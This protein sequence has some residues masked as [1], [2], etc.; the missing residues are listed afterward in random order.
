M[1]R[2]IKKITSKKWKLVGSGWKNTPGTNLTFVQNPYT[3]L[4]LFI[5]WLSPLVMCVHQ[6]DVP[7]WGR[8]RTSS[9]CKEEHMMI[10]FADW[11]DQVVTMDS[12]DTHHLSLHMFV[13]KNWILQIV[14]GSLLLTFRLSGWHHTTYS[15]VFAD[16]V[17]EKNEACHCVAGVIEMCPSQFPGFQ[18]FHL[19]VFRG[20]SCFPVPSVG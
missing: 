6:P 4:Y 15:Y 5:F 10:N 20:L 17:S 3:C 8:H 11:C 16:G 12:L 9:M 1:C 2:K 13:C 18:L 19:L 7:V 14:H